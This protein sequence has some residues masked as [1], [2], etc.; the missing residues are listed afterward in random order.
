MKSNSRARKGSVELQRD[1]RKLGP[2][3]FPI[4]ERV[5]SFASLAE[6]ETALTEPGPIRS[7]WEAQVRAGALR[8][9]ERRRRK[10]KCQTAQD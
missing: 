8:E 1:P 6:L 2:V 9:I 7:A 10:K 4:G 5:L 3:S